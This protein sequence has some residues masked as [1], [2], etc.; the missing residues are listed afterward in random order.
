MHVNYQLNQLRIKKKSPL[1]ALMETMPSVGPF[2]RQLLR[3]KGISN[4]WLADQLKIGKSSMSKKLNQKSWHFHDM[5]LVSRLL[6]VNLFDMACL[7]ED[8]GSES[9]KDMISFSKTKKIEITVVGDQITTTS[10]SVEETK[11][12]PE[13]TDDEK[14]DGA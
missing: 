3:Q 4:K 9:L 5:V 13:T 8:F 11:S 2:V 1:L 7:D 6:Q 10:V 14:E 12:E